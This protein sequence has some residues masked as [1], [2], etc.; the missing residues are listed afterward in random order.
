MKKVNWEDRP[1]EVGLVS[2][3]TASFGIEEPFRTSPISSMT[4]Q[5]LRAYV[6]EQ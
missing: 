3:A 1:L 6:Y 5:V 2:D 4:M